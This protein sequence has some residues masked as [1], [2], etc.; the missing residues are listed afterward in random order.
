M[1]NTIGELNEYEKRKYEKLA[2]EIEKEIEKLDDVSFK[3][4]DSI[5]MVYMS[6]KLHANRIHDKFFALIDYL[7]SIYGE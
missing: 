3:D 5:D 7:K 1:K 4:S 6:L 2:S